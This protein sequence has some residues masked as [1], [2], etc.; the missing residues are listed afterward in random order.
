MRT[1][2]WLGARHLLI[3]G[4][5]TVSSSLKKKKIYQRSALI[6][7]YSSGESTG[8]WY[9]PLTIKCDVWLYRK[10]HPG[11][12]NHM[13]VLMHWFKLRVAASACRRHHAQWLG[14]C[15]DC[16]PGW[17]FCGI[18]HTQMASPAGAPGECDSS[19]F[20][21]GCLY[22]TLGR[23]SSEISREEAWLGERSG[24][25]YGMSHTICRHR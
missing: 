19:G 15:A 4:K 2:W 5:S 23:V 10:L 8:D 3:T 9:I 6:T 14:V 22:H 25:S 21:A 17:R 24:S 18:V 1:N 11:A 20:F 7:A 13:P 16:C 12:P